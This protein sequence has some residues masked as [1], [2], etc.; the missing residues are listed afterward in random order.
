MT[1]LIKRKLDRHGTEIAA[2]GALKKRVFLH[3]V[4]ATG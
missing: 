1:L 4:W 2:S 3:L